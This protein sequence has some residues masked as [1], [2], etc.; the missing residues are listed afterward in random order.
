MTK[1]IQA[2]ANLIGVLFL[3]TLLFSCDFTPRFH[4]R[5][6]LAQEYL[7]QHDYDN[8]INQYKMI[9][10]DNPSD[11]I[12]VKINY[13]L[14][15]ILSLNLGQNEEALT[16]YLTV[17]TLTE[18]P[19]WLIKTEERIA[20]INFSFLRDYKSSSESYLKLTNFK[21]RLKRFDFYEYRLSRS[22]MGKKN[23]DKAEEVLKKIRSNPNSEYNVR[24]Y[25]ELGMI[26][27]EKKK[28]KY[29]IAFWKEYIKRETRRDNII[30]TRFLMANAYETMENLKTAYNIYYS[31]LG[32]YPNTEVIQNRL[33][34]IY[35]RR[36]AR[37]R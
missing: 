32:E 4:K 23:Y 12:K 15:E 25:Y 28:W 27:F 36:V 30:Q 9:L 31:I 7:T 24:S 29:A 14:G 22:Y 33:N 17:K 16:Y 11:D 2:K 8:A 21:P 3:S 26:N 37:K 5:I 10:R 34:S 18:D 20:D 6:L 35:T 1:K 13:Q 19:L